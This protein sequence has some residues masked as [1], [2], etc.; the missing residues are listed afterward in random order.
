MAIPISVDTV[1]ASTARAAIDAGA[2]I[3]NDISALRFDPHMAHVVASTGAGLV[4]MHMRGDPATMMRLEPSN[5]ILAE[6]ER[7]LLVAL[8][9]AVDS[10]VALDRVVIDPG[11]GFGKTL[12]QNVEILARLG[13]VARLDRPLLIGTSR[14]S[15]L[16]KLT[17][18]STDERLAASIA[19]V[20]A[21]VLRG[22]HIVRVHD[23]GP[24]VDAV[25]VADALLDRTPR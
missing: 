8:E 23:V 16:G 9:R 15:F 6:I 4:L 12:D 11:I 22:A 25:R 17:G 18:R 5:D 24:A 20:T 19:S 13:T 1:R 21:A 14:K 10:G 3:V 2:R 7:D